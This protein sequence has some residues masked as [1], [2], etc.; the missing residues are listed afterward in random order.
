[1]K[2][3][4]IWSVGEGKGEIDENSVSET[5]MREVEGET[6]GWE[7]KETNEARREKEGEVAVGFL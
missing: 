7:R 2:L 3:R 4:F 6:A 1:M 5:D